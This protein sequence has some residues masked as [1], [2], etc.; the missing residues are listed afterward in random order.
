MYPSRVLIVL[1]E[2]FAGEVGCSLCRAPSA[3]AG[4]R[5]GGDFGGITN[6]CTTDAG[7]GNFLD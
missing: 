6:A 7:D 4:L 2:R 5:I 3:M 1:A